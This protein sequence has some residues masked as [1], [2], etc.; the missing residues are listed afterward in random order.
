MKNNYTKKVLYRAGQN[1]LGVME[2]VIVL[3][4]SVGVLA[5]IL[6]IFAGNKQSAV[7]QESLGRMQENARLALQT[8]K[9]DLRHAGFS[10]EIQ[11]YWNIDAVPATSPQHID[12]T[13]VTGECFNN[14]A[15]GGYRWAAPLVSV[16][17]GPILIPPKLYGVDDMTDGSIAPF[18]GCMQSTG[19]TPGTDV[20][21]VH[22]AG[23]DGVQDGGFAL[24]AG[25]L[26]LRS[27]LFNGVV[28]RSAGGAPPSTTNWTDGP[29]T[30]IY[31]LHAATY[32]VRS[33]KDTGG[34][35][36]CNGGSGEDTIPTL[37]RKVLL[38]NGT[39]GTEIVA[40]GVAG[41]QVRY[42]VDTDL[43][44]DGIVDQYV[45]AGH[46]RLSSV[47]DSANWANWAR[48]RTV[49]IWLLMRSAEK[50]AGYQDSHAHYVLAD[51]NFP[52]VAGYRYQLFITTVAVRN[53]SGDD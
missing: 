46:S 25:R 20:L 45:D 32:F 31:Q 6:Q 18:T 28:F 43:S 23:P 19:F 14:T 51:T 38:D 1:G 27:N 37:V 49:R 52:T 22:F 48:V 53:P 16:G 7:L 34:D 36:L 40:E 10:G 8:L 42:G 5:I 30:L 13:P 11:E 26:Y 15:A 24:T 21:S 44:T 50:F 12:A 35:E 41:F 17:S 3:A 47:T 33:C 2:M 4:L 9:E 29:N 39:V